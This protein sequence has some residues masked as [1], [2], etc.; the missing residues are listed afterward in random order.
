MGP[1]N[2]TRSTTDDNGDTP[3]PLALRL[4]ELLNDDQVIAKLKQALLPKELSDKIEAL[5]NHISQ[6]T[7]QID[8]KDSRIKS[9]EEK[10]LNQEIS[11]DSVEQYSRRVIIHVCGIPEADG[12]GEDADEKVLAV[13][14]GKMGMQPPVQR[15]Q[16]ERSHRLGRKGRQRPTSPS[17]RRGAFRQRAA[18]R[19]RVSGSHCAENARRRTPRSP[20]LPKRGSYRAQRQAGLRHSPAEKG[21]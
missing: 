14:N 13:L 4:I 15:Q 16:I 3:D 1:K 8:A 2:K 20:D 10:V 17:N 12:G 9:L 11:A 6:L 18:A 19:R 21:T 7:A 5:N